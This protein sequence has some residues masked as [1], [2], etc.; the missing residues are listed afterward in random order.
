MEVGLVE[1]IQVG[2]VGGIA[3]RARALDENA[4]SKLEEAAAGGCLAVTQHTID[5]PSSS[6]PA[7]TAHVAILTAAKLG[8]EPEA[9]LCPGWIV[10]PTPNA[11]S[12]YG[13]HDSV[14]R[15][16]LHVAHH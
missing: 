9:G 8:G 12:E 15:V 13:V 1:A 6:I 10:R 4:D 5:G 16:E 11:R 3:S 7:L 2:L 14:D